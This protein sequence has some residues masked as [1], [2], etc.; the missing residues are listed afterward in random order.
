MLKILIIGLGGFVGAVARYGLS[1]LLHKQFG[2]NFPYGTFAV[3]IMGCFCIGALMYFV[4]AKPVVSQNLRLFLGIGLLGAFTTFS[5]FGYET[6][7]LL[8]DKEFV[9][10]TIYVLGNVIIGVAAV[11]LGRTV[12]KA[13]GI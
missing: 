7:A 3:N 5:T 10:A 4:D 6:L 13:I 9:R 12:L 8:G 2:S 1:G 11:W